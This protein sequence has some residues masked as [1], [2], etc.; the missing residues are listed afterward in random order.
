MRIYPPI[1]IMRKHFIFQESP[2]SDKGNSNGK[3][4]AIVR[5]QFSEAIRYAEQ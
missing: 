1:M 4:H 3:P 5:S 2:G